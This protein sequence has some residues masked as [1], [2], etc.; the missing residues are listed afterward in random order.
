MDRK[1]F[2]D[3][4]ECRKNIPI[5][6]NTACVANERHMSQY[7][8][9]MLI[10]QDETFPMIDPC[11]PGF[12]VIRLTPYQASTVHTLI[13]IVSRQLIECETGG[14]NN[15][16]VI[17]RTNMARL[18]E[19][20]GTGKSVIM[21]AL[22]LSMRGKL[23]KMQP[24]MRIMRYGCV[25]NNFVREIAY[26]IDLPKSQL[27][28][29]ALFL[30][31][32][33]V[34]EQWVDLIS[35]CTHGHKFYVV[36]GMQDMN[37][38]LE[39]IANGDIKKYTFVVAVNR[40]FSGK[41]R[42]PKELGET[43]K[44]LKKTSHKSYIILASIP[45]TW[46]LL[47]IDDADT[48]GVPDTSKL[49]PACFRIFG[50]STNKI[51]EPAINRKSRFDSLADMLQNQTQKYGDIL[52]NYT[53]VGL[54][55]VRSK[56]LYVEKENGLSEPRYYALH[57]KLKA[58]RL[59]HLMGVLGI[60]EANAIQERINNG[61]FESAASMAGIGSNSVESIFQKLLGDSFAVYK[62]AEEDLALIEEIKS[63]IESKELISMNK[64]P[65]P[66]DAR[67][68]ME[69]FN[70]RQVPQYRY[71]NLKQ[72]I[73]EVEP[74]A[75]ERKNKTGAAIERVQSS[76]REGSCP[77]CVGELKEAKGMF[78]LTCCATVYCVDCTNKLFHLG[79]QLAVTQSC[80]TCRR[81]INFK[82]LVFVGKNFNIEGLADKYALT[83]ESIQKQEEDMKARPAK[84]D[85]KSDDES[86]DEVTDSSDTDSA[87]DEPHIKEAKQS[88]FYAELSTLPPPEDDP[89]T[90][91]QALAAICKG[92][93][94][95]VNTTEFKCHMKNVMVGSAPRSDAKNN[96]V[97]IFANVEKALKDIQQTLTKYEIKFLTLTGDS[98]NI[99]RM[100]KKFNNHVGNIALV[101][102][103]EK[104]CAG[105]N[106]QSATHV[107]MYGFI[108]NISVFEQ[109]LGRGQRI[110]RKSTLN[111]IILCYDNEYE[112][113]RQTLQIIGPKPS[114]LTGCA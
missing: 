78:I 74:K 41:V 114:K 57:F 18:S 87:E 86:D 93:A 60:D 25:S 66:E 77:I 52:R 82:S 92:I 54:L 73:D 50:S 71:P 70:S 13:G 48:I 15:K 65:D 67:Y 53:L 105:M 1:N 37:L 83:I 108:P 62:K 29:T 56:K 49:L 75:T 59:V 58:D 84:E 4:F 76:L 63:L 64:N 19:M 79:S 20:V 46:R 34:I 40:D 38:L 94:P 61:D 100:A 21:I 106:L 10:E 99:A 28:E 43:P 113:L 30:V 35:T 107:I 91:L 32:K 47:Y 96:K 97:L 80:R 112:T 23:A 110:G 24:E 5:V 51:P 2:S 14:K 16:K 85:S 55:N 68:S 101:I 3:W 88:K 33:S 45:K 22:V 11:V 42:W 6:L 27:L 111:I 109:T 12:D 90:K 36:R 9:K 8:A 26:T 69:M 72:I 102:S 95:P 17:I 98:K 89:Y 31:G 7:E 44:E 103:S 39:M 104:Q 81:Q